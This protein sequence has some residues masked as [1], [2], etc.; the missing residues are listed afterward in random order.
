MCGHAALAVLL[1]R[2]VYPRLAPHRRRALLGWWSAKLLRILNVRPRIEGHPPHSHERGAMI[3][4][5]HVSW[6]DIFLVAGVHP[7]RFIAKSE[8]RQWGLM[9][10][11]AERAGTLF[12]RRDQLR[13][14]ARINAVVHDALAGGDCVGLFPEG[15]TT[16]GDELRKFHSALFEAAVANEAHVHPAAIRYERGD[17]SLCREASFRGE[18]TFF[19]SLSLIIAEPAIVARIGFAPTVETAGAHRRDVAA[20]CEARIASLLGLSPSR[21]KAPG[22]ASGLPAEAR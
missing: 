6:L 14:T 3:A 8:I 10:W 1:L 13:D 19:Q 16:E 12:I 17:G 9:G 18:R 21:G 2:A 15:I 11:I 4:A 7:T 20:Q 22:R 5:N